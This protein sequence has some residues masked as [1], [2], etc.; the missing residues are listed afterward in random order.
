MQSRQEG[1]KEYFLKLTDPSDTRLYFTNKV[2]ETR[3]YNY[4][5]YE[6]MYNGGG[7]AIG[8]INNDGLADIYLGGN[9]VFDKLYLNKG[10]LQFED[11]SKSSGISGIHGGWSTGINM[12]D[13]N[14]DG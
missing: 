11:I 10:N 12:V 8:D 13:I 9:S 1:P 2:L 14:G 4:L 6:S 7:V 5:A 3:D